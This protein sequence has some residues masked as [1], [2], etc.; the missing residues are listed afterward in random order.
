MARLY[1]NENLPLQA[2]E[3][4]R[5]LGH[6]VLTTQQTGKAGQAISDAQVLAFARAEGRALLTLNR[7]HFV[8]L[9]LTDPNH[10]GII[11]C[12]LDVDFAALARRI[13]LAIAERTV[14][15]GQLMRIN[16]PA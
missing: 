7:R 12:T 9:H 16:R 1:A 4:L 8:R 5:Q 15:A 2:V 11:V 6:D 14:L 13:D 3:E 10:E